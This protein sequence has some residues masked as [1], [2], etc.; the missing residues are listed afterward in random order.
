M[1]K[2]DRYETNRRQ[3]QHIIDM[4]R[5]ILH[6]KLKSTLKMIF[7]IGIWAS[8]LH[9]DSTTS[10]DIQSVFAQ[11]FHSGGVQQLEKD[12]FRH[13]P[14]AAFGDSDKRIMSEDD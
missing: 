13:S 7:W 8:I 4:C 2:Y 5:E 10:H 1:S 14:D 3:E 12:I 9:Q 6:H 11:P